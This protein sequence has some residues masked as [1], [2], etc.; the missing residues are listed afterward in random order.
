MLVP[1][2]SL[3]AAMCTPPPAEVAAVPYATQEMMLDTGGLL[4]MI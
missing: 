1:V 3:L 2:L 4:S